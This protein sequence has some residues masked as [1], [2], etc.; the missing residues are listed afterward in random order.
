MSD[1]NFQNGYEVYVDA[2]Y[3]KR[4]NGRHSLS[5]YADLGEQEARDE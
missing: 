5:D 2:L 1:R 3:T 4:P